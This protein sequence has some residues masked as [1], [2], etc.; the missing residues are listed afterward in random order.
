MTTQPIYQRVS[1]EVLVKVRERL[2][3]TLEDCNLCPR[4]CGV[5]RISGEVGYCGGGALATVAS[6]GPHFG[7]ER[8]L[9]GSYGSGTIFFSGCPLGCVFCQNYDISSSTIGNK[10][11]DDE[12]AKIMLKLEDMG[13]HNINLVTPTHYIPQIV[14]AII[15][16][17][18]GGLSIP[19]VYNTGGYDLPE[20]IEILAP[21]ID[22]FMPD[23][24]FSSGEVAERFCNAYDYPE[25]NREA[26]K[27][28]HKVVGDLKVDEYGIAMRGLIIRHLVLPEGM[29]GTDDIVNFIATEISNKTY[30]NLME[31]YY[32]AYKSHKY[33]E[34]SRRITREEWQE[35]VEQTHR[36][37][38]KIEK[39]FNIL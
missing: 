3:H 34:L 10:Y 14:G 20:T 18:E 4:K 24:K 9:V 6:Y 38:L 37:G 31:Q 29:A 15:K 36:A 32:P 19:I 26:V 5:N 30:F 35:A 12:I 21:V 27:T 33:R 7:E 13:C 16:A 17:R 25:I 39:A 1:E 2:Y 28:M 22:I 8:P 11:S 23:M